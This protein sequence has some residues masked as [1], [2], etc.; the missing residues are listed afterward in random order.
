[1]FSRNANLGHVE[2]DV[3]I[4]E[5]PI[6]WLKSANIRLGKCVG[7][8]STFLHDI[9]QPTSKLKR[10]TLFLVCALRRVYREASFDAAL[11]VE[12]GAT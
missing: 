4:R 12:S 3:C 6:F 11:D 7:D 10:A 9:S 2:M 8:A 1:M 5:D